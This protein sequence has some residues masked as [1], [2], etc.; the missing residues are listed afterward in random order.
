MPMAQRILDAGIEDLSAPR[1]ATGQSCNEGSTAP[2]GVVQ[3]LETWTRQHADPLACEQQ[4]ES[5]EGVESA[6]GPEPTGG[7]L[8]TSVTFAPSLHSGDVHSA[9]DTDSPVSGKGSGEEVP[10]ARRALPVLRV[11]ELPEE[12]QPIL[13]DSPEK[14]RK[15]VFGRAAPAMKVA[16]LEDGAGEDAPVDE[17]AE[18]AEP[19]LSMPELPQELQL[20]PARS[21]KKLGNRMCSRAAPAQIEQPSEEGN[22]EEDPWAKMEEA[23]EPVVRVP[24]PPQP[25]LCQSPKKL[26]KRAFTRAARVPAQIEELCEEDGGEDSPV[27]QRAERAELGLHMPEV[28]HA[29]QPIRDGPLVAT[30][31]GSRSSFAFRLPWE[32]LSN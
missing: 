31:T 7:A 19:V 8:R 14:L 23:A 20:I 15:C 17:I 5:L 1:Q 11:P 24:E 3:S 22:G 21:P 29:M 26:G 25:I 12:L 28:L 18:M 13:S 16:L 4:D 6:H 27:A 32:V 30:V 2:E 10:V 9:E